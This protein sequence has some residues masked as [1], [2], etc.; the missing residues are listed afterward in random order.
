M[1]VSL[2]AATSALP[3]HLPACDPGDLWAGLT[4]DDA[5]RIAAALAA[6]HAASTRKV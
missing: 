3:A 1:P 2:T 5:T 4:E 6:T